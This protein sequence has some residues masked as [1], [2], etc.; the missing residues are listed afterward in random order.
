MSRLPFETEVMCGPSTMVSVTPKTNKQREFGAA[1]VCGAAFR[2]DLRL[3]WISHVRM[4]KDTCFS[5]N[6]HGGT[7][8][9]ENSHGVVRDL[10]E[11]PAHRIPAAQQRAVAASKY[12][13]AASDAG[14]LCSGN[15]GTRSEGMAC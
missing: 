5:Y 7:G 11:D 1:R 15:P 8:L 2:G 14:L 13:N 10:S 6:S 9:C 3:R 12:A 4:C